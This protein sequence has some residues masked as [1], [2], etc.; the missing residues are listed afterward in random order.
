MA[1]LDSWPSAYF[2]RHDSLESQPLNALSG[3]ESAMEEFGTR[4]VAD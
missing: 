4:R 2:E 1:A 3:A